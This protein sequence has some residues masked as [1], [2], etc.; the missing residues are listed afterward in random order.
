MVDVCFSDHDYI[1]D[2][3]SDIQQFK[4]KQKESKDSRGGWERML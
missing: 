4:N 3:I 2:K 1:R